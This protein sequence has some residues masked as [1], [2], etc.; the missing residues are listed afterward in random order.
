MTAEESQAL[1][2]GD[3][4]K[5]MLDTEDKGTVIGHTNHTIRVKWDSNG[6]TV[7]HRSEMEQFS[8]AGKE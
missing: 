7:H 6:I 2:L 8:L 5:W 1:T 3:R 4:L